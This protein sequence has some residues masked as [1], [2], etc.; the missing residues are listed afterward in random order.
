MMM[1]VKWGNT[2]IFMLANSEAADVA[3]NSV[4]NFAAN[5]V[6]AAPYVENDV[7]LVPTSFSPVL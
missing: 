3:G 7:H 4:G 5:A 6:A 2:S 1:N